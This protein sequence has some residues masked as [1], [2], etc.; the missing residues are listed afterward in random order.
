V[1]SYSG[2]RVGRRRHFRA[3]E[4]VL[5]KGI[6][7]ASADDQTASLVAEQLRSMGEA[8]GGG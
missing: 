6:E 8:V 2:L 4:A 1:D 7:R 5:L 3:L